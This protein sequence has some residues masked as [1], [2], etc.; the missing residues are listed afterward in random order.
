MSTFDQAQ[1]SGA[2]KKR[3]AGSLFPHFC[4]PTRWGYVERRDTEKGIRRLGFP[5]RPFYLLG[6]LGILLSP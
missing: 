2:F 4:S 6:D 5:P 3:E 1:A